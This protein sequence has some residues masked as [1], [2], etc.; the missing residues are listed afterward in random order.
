[1]PLCIASQTF[2]CSTT[3]QTKQWPRWHIFHTST[4]DYCDSLVIVTWSKPSLSNLLVV[5]CAVNLL[6]LYL[7]SLRVSGEEY[8]LNDMD[9]GIRQFYFFFVFFNFLPH[10]LICS[11]SLFFLV[12][13]YT[14]ISFGGSFII[15]FLLY[16]VPPFMNSLT[17]RW[18]IRYERL[19]LLG[20]FAI[21]VSR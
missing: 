14:L 5:H 17:N 16:N 21:W 9:S 8:S 13:I 6:F 1:M 20:N 11:C 7:S 19:S 12:D 10:C 2:N 18:L 15:N 3:L 4:F